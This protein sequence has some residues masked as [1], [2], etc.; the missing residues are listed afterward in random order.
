MGDLGVGGTLSVAVAGADSGDLATYDSDDDTSYDT[1]SIVKVDILASLLLRD[2]RAG[3][4]LTAYQRGS[5]TAMI[6]HSDNDAAT[7]LY[8]DLGGASGLDAAERA[9][10]AEAHDRRRG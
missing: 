9:A 3:T 7:A 2:Q 5:A 10:R 4:E 1:A 6:E 8:D